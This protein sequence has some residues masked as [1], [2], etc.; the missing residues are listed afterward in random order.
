MSEPIDA[1]Y[2]AQIAVGIGSCMLKNDKTSREILYADLSAE[3]LKRVLR[4]QTRF[5]LQHMAA[6]TAIQGIDLEEAYY[7]WQTNIAVRAAN[8]EFH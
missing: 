8:G 2:A 4:W 3:D 5:L 1:N 6:L 7:A